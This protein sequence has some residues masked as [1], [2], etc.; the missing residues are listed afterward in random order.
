ME[1]NS[2][3][4]LFHA[5]ELQATNK[6]TIAKLFNEAMTILYPNGIE[7]NNVFL[8]LTDSAAYMHAAAAGL[9]VSLNLSIIY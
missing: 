3:P 2:T 4:Y 1:R 9:Q 6:H 5:S 7:F 8:F